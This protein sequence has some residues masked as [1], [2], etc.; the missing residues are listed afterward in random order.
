[1]KVSRGSFLK[2]CGAAALGQRVD[3]DVWFSGFTGARSDPATVAP[4]PSVSRF[5]LQDACAA[6]FRPHVN[7]AFTVRS[8]ADVRVRLVLARVVDGPR[9]E[10]VE[11]FSLIFHGPADATVSHDTHACHHPAL[12][13]FDLFIVPIGGSNTRRTVCEACFS[14]HLAPAER[15]S[16][17]V[18]ATRVEDETC[19]MSS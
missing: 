9:T 19:R 10:S 16:G 2:T 7:T 3:A 1:V 8:P 18:G 13:S 14:R 6:Q 5:R 11:Q 17:D 12:G 4:S 15:A